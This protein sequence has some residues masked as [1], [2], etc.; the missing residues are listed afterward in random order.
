MAA[1]SLLLLLIQLL[2]FGQAL[3]QPGEFLFGVG[4]DGLKAYTA[5]AWQLMH[6]EGVW[7][8]LYMHPHGTHILY[9][10]INPMLYFVLSGFQTLGVAFDPARVITITNS[11]LLLGMYPAL[12]LLYGIG[13]RMQLPDWWSA[14]L[15]VITVCL[16][17]QLYRFGGHFSMAQLWVVPLLWW[18]LLNWHQRPTSWISLIFYFLTG[19]IIAL[20]HPYLGLMS[21][22]FLLMFL[23]AGWRGA[24]RF[25]MLPLWRKALT[26]ILAFLPV[27]V[28]L[29]W[30]AITDQ[31]PGDAV[32]Y[33]FGFRFYRAGFESIFVANDGPVRAFIDSILRI[34]HYN[35]EGFAYVGITGFLVLVALLVM[36]LI[37][38]IPNRWTAPIFWQEAP[39]PLKH[40]VLAGTLILIPAMVIPVNWVPMLEDYLGPLRQFRSPGR[41]A[42]VFFYVYMIFVGWLL[43]QVRA[44]VQARKTVFAGLALLVLGAMLWLAEGGILMQQTSSSILGQAKKD[45]PEWNVDWQEELSHLD[46]QP[47]EYQGIIAL[48][49][50]FHGTEK[51]Y[52]GSWESERYAHVI[53][54]RT[55]LPLVNNFAARAS[56]SQSR[57][58]IQLVSHP[59]IQ[60]D[61]PE[62]LTDDDRPFLLMHHNPSSLLPGESWLL[63]K[64]KALGN[65][66]DIDFY[67]LSMDRLRESQVEPLWTDLI[68]SPWE[69]SCMEDRCDMVS[70]SFGDAPRETPGQMARHTDR[71]NRLVWEGLLRVE[72][73]DQPMEISVWIKLDQTSDYLPDLKVTQWKENSLVFTQKMIT[74]NTLDVWGEWAIAR[75]TLSLRSFVTRIESSPKS[76]TFDRLLIRP[77]DLNVVS[78]TPTDDQQLRLWNNY[79]LEPNP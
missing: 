69:D 15:A 27:L 78:F 75:D 47:D 46:I 26:A 35:M 72:S 18:W 70:A 71:W 19:I 21:G 10:D 25:G 36:W 45:V 4:G 12:W 23:I 53:A 24:E 60:R 17:P 50:F 39:E 20:L 33:P 6:G 65:L 66:D 16:S 77:L 63:S 13:R 40:S 37:R 74:M 58:A 29:A 9:A 51:I 34:R 61:Y 68:E 43:V 11:L 7:H 32:K 31:G 55:G 41:L 44:Y 30:T 54:L 49:F 52:R 76:F 59:L 14:L 48:P 1:A 67:L 64:G 8:S 38:R 73:P 79:P 42:W 5:L 56:L 3:W 62:A 2:F 28:L 22:A 57:Q